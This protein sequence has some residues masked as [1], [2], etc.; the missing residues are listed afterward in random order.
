MGIAAGASLVLLT[1]SASSLILVGFGLLPALIVTRAGKTARYPSRSLSLSTTL[2]MAL[3]WGL[4]LITALILLL[5]LGVSLG[6]PQSAAIIVALGV[7]LALLGALSARRWTLRSDFTRPGPGGWVAIVTLGLAALYLAVAALGPVTNYDSGLYHLGAIR[8]ASE[9]PAIP[10]LANLYFPLGYS[11]SHFP[12]AALLTNGPWG[13]EGFRLLNGLIMF[14]ASADVVLRLLAKKKTAGLFVLAAGVL[15]AW[16]PMIALSDYWVT[17]PSQDSA[18]LVL[19]VVASA[20]FIDAVAARGGWL[21]AG[22][23]ALAIGGVLVSIRLTLAPYVVMVGLLLVA[24]AIRRRPSTANITHASIPLGLLVALLAAG[25]AFRDRILS[26]WLGYPGSVFALDVPWRTTDPSQF[27]NAILGFHRNPED[28][29]GSIQGWNWIGPWISSRSGQWETYEFIAFACLALVL[30]ALVLKRESTTPYLRVAIIGLAPS[31]VALGIWWL[32]TPP[33]YRFIWGPLLTLAT[34]PI[35]LAWWRL[36]GTTGRGA[37]VNPRKLT[38]SLVLWAFPIVL[39]TLVSGIFRFDWS[40]VNSPYRVYPGLD[41][42][43][44]AIP[45]A[46]TSQ[47]VMPSGLVIEI[48]VESDQC[49]AVYPLCSPD[50]TVGLTPIGESIEHGFTPG[51]DTSAP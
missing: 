43:I 26:G 48:P 18:A 14:L 6:G 2:R 5:S 46:A 15:A 31:V 45:E 27:R 13:G 19:T 32:V 47:Q 42:V 41:I 16:V 25:V 11:T 33:S 49:W 28:I 39:V 10:G 35:G 34:V 3:W 7:P 38:A 40:L 12:L 4:G 29:G 8:Y 22:A 50:P 17:S 21:P 1:W 24:L 23:T 37:S 20:Y 51:L 30:T 36:S 9:F 44:A